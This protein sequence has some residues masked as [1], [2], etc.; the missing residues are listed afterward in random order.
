MCS[1]IFARED[2]LTRCHEA[3]LDYF[4]EFDDFHEVIAGLK[5]L[6]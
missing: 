5:R 4:S 2:L 6:T 1:H 3:K